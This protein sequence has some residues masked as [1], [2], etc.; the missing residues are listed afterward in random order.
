VISIRVATLEDFA[1]FELHEKNIEEIKVSS[2]IEPGLCIAALYET[3]EQKQIVLLDNKPICISGLVDKHN[4]W[5]FFSAEI[6]NLPL[7]FFKETRKGLNN[8]LNQ[9][10]YIDGYIYSKNTFALQWA[11]FMKITIEEPKAYGVNGELFHYFF[12][13][14]E[15]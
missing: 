12:K 1:L 15:A 2:G 5:L 14:K 11:K 6:E 10:D 7:S 13:R 8:L 9:C 4:L 3:S